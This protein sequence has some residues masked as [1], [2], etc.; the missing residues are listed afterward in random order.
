MPEKMYFDFEEKKFKNITISQVQFWESCYPDVDVIGHLT[1]KMPGWLDA[2]ADG[3]GKKK[4]WKIFIVNW[5]SR[6]QERY[7]QFK[8]PE[9][10][11]D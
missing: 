7:E 2:N 9:G 1:K 4:Q 6:Q 5:L 8:K 3:K 11:V 10:I